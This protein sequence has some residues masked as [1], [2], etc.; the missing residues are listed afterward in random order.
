VANATEA[1]K[2]ENLE[3]DI[4]KPHEKPRKRPEYYGPAGEKATLRACCERK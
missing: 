1:T 2:P 3:R 4:N